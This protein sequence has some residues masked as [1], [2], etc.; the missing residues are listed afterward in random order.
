MPTAMTLIPFDQ[1]TNS[2]LK[3]LATAFGG[4]EDDEFLSGQRPSF[5]VISIKGSKF[6]VTRGGEREVIVNE[7]GDARSS[8]D[9]V[10]VRAVKGLSKV[11]YKDTYEEGSS[12]APDCY[13][14][15]GVVPAPDAKVPQAKSCAACPNNVWG[16]KINEKTGK[17][18]KLCQDSKRLAVAPLGQLNDPMLLRVPAASLTNWDTCVATLAKK[19]LKVPAVALKLGFDKDAAYPLLTFRPAALLPEGLIAQVQAARTLDVTMA[20]VGETAL[21]DEH[22]APV[23]V[24]EDEPLPTLAE[25]EPEKAKAAPKA[26]SKPG[27]K[28][29]PKA[30]PADD[31][32]L[33][34]LEDALA[35]LSF[36]SG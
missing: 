20:I 35:G 5:P 28:A 14:N 7:D 31:P 30:A 36:E 22:S 4:I 32:L 16:S 11:F 21:P 27:P 24:A 17:K 1:V 12:E 9:I 13:S 23:D 25:P 6:A 29:V 33:A 2:S 34:G 10:V 26:E 3:A 18:G 19:G 15:S 8:I